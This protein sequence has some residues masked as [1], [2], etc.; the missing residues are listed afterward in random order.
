[1]PLRR[2]H[3]ATLMRSHQA[4]ITRF[5]LLASSFIGVDIA[6]NTNRLRE[7]NPFAPLFG[8]GSYVR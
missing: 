8:G 5:S 3:Y 6:G 1:M 2:D 7:S 4:A